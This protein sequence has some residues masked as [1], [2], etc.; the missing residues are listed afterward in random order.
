MLVVVMIMATACQK[1]LRQHKI[2][3]KEK[4]VKICVSALNPRLRFGSG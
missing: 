4:Q 2:S 1:T 3:K